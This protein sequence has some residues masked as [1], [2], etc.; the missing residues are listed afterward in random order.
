M[1]AFSLDFRQRV[2]AAYEQGEG[3]LAELA[4]RFRV[5]TFFIVKMLG[6]HR[7]GDSLAPKPHGGGAPAARTDPQ[8]AVLRTA[9]DDRP[10]A[11]LKELQAV[12]ASR[13]QVTVSEATICRELQELGLPRKKKASS[14]V[15]ATP[16]SAGRF[17]ARSRPG[18]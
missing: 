6:L 1:K 5:G 17:A 7:R 14:P 13:R 12:L 9:M 16:A 2:V 15:S 8:R 4:A 11:T 10:D 18:R 3:A